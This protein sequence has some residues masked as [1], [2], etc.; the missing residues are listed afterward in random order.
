MEHLNERELLLL[1]MFEYLALHHSESSWRERTT[2]S[3]EQGFSGGFSITSAITVDNRRDNCE[4]SI[5]F[6]KKELIYHAWNENHH[7]GDPYDCLSEQLPWMIVQED[8]FLKHVRE[9]FDFFALSVAKKKLDKERDM[10]LIAV[11]TAAVLGHDI[12]LK[13]YKS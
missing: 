2:G 3:Y 10:Q 7:N 6:L 4:W 11:E 12:A 8:W 1:K 5:N 9:K 13:W